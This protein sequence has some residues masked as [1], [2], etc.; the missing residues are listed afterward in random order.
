[1]SEELQVLDELQK[2]ENSV[3]YFYNTYTTAGKSKPLPD[4]YLDSQTDILTLMYGSRLFSFNTFRRQ[5][6]TLITFKLYGKRP[7]NSLMC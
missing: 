3:T 1:M 2:C 5:L 4:G 6:S 7:R